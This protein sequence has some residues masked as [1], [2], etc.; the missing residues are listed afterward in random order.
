MAASTWP[1]SGTDRVRRIGTD[2]VIETV[3]GGGIVSHDGV[4]ATEFSIDPMGIALDSEGA[5]FVADAGWVYRV[6]GDGVIREIAGEPCSGGSCPVATDQRD[7]NLA[8]HYDLGCPW[9]LA[10]GHARDVYVTDLCGH[11]IRRLEPALP[12]FDAGD[13]AVASEDGAELYEFS[14]EGRHLR[15]RDALT[16]DTVFSF[17]YDGQGRLAAIEDGDGLET[18]I[19]R[20]STGAPTA[21]VAPFG[22]RT[23]LGLGS[24]GYLESLVNPADEETTFGYGEGGLLASLTTAEGHET[25]FTYDDSGRL[26]RDTDAAGGFKELERTVGDDRSEVTLTTKLGRESEYEVERLPDDDVRRTWTDPSGLERSLLVR[27]DGR[28]EVSGSDGLTTEIDV[29]PDPRFGAQAPV[30]TKRI[31][32]T[33]GGRR[34]EAQASRDVTLADPGHPL[35]LTTI[36]EV[37]SVNGREASTVFDAAFEPLRLHIAGGTCGNDH[38]RPTAQAGRQLDDWSDACRLCARCLRARRAG[39]PGS[40]DRRLR[41]RRAGTAGHGQRRLGPRAQL[42]VRR[43]RPSGQGGSAS[44]DQPNQ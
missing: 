23:A 13:I 11:T 7:G 20:N 18:T 9:G 3:V 24:A 40:A 5:L 2:G 38:G 28:A 19:E 44:K 29:G 15:T 36:E 17:S 32:E 43:R 41:L 14:P 6:D 37:V 25:T 8:G 30:P 10:A 35:S 39:R 1:T 16:G 26:T 34:M 4:P 31:V 42:R 21:I 22:R 12:D 27:D 33:P